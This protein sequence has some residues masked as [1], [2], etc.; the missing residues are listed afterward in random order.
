MHAL[1]SVSMRFHRIRSIVQAGMIVAAAP[2]PAGGWDI[3]VISDGRLVAAAHAGPKEDARAVARAARATAEDS[4]NSTAST[5][6]EETWLLARWIESPD[7]RLVSIDAP[8][9]WPIRAGSTR[10]AAVAPNSGVGR[11]PRSTTARPVGP[12][13]GTTK[14]SRIAH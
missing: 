3:H 7:V 12:A 11:L 5:T 1:V 10:F 13:P 14:V 9:I 8:L 6:F 2:A 4:T